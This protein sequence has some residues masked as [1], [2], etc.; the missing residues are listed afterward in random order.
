MTPAQGDTPTLGDRLRAARAEAGLSIRELARLAGINYSYL[1]KL[2]SDQN[3]NPSADKLQRLAGVLD[4][5][6]AELLGYIGVEPSG[7]LPPP[8]VYFRRKYGVSE[9]D[10]EELSRIIESYTKQR[11]PQG[12]E[13]DK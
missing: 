12:G 2:E 7:T 3:D 11:K 4:I 1:S 10:A 8:R 6:P 13:H 5:D 9:Q